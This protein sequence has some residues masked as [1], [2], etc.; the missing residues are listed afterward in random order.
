MFS[1]TDHE[2][3]EWTLADFLQ[4]NGELSLDGRLAAIVDHRC[5]PTL[6]KRAVL[7]FCRLEIGFFLQ[8]DPLA[9]EVM[10]RVATIDN[11]RTPS[12]P[13]TEGVRGPGIAS[14]CWRLERAW[15]LIETD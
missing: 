4:E 13:G 1:P 14:V 12:S 5:S 2:F 11:G 7:D 6:A 9:A 3:H 10:R 15:R 8:N